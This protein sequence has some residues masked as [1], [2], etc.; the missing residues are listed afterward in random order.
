MLSS[1]CCIKIINDNSEPVESKNELRQ[2]NSLECLL[3][4]RALEKVIRNANIHGW[5]N[6]FYKSIQ[7]LAFADDIDIIAPSEIDIRQAFKVIR[8]SAEEMGLKV[9]ERKTKYMVVGRSRKKTE[10]HIL[11]NLN[12][13]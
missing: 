3:F 1:Q 9:N 7:L 11:M 12:L 6:I 5:G 8:V 2:S 13:R 4:N 10:T